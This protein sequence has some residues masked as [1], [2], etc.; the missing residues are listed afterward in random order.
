MY[1]GKIQS[2]ISFQHHE[3]KISTN[4]ESSHLKKRNIKSEIQYN[5]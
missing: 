4:E 1:T 3:N 5:K 2:Y